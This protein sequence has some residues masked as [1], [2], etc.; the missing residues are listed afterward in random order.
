MREPVKSAPKNMR[1]SV[2][3]RLLNI[4]RERGQTF[5]L[6]LVRYTLERLLYR[7][8][9]SAHRDDFVLKGAML[10]TTWLDNAHRPTRD[11]DLLGFGPSQPEA[12]LA[13]FREI[14]GI[15]AD[16]GVAFDAGALRIERNREDLEY[17]GLRVVTD[18]RIGG[19][20]VRVV[21][22]VGFGDA[23][24]PGL[25]EIELPVLLDLPAPRLRAYPKETVIAEK[26]QAM[27]DLG[28]AN[29]RMKDFY[30]I[31]FLARTFAFEDD[32]LA[33]AIAATFA[34]RKTDIPTEAPDAL[35]DAFAQD[36][37]KRKQWEAFASSI[38]GEPVP[39]DVV[40]KDLRKFLLPHA[41]AARARRAI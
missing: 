18:A 22:D 38:I 3:A 39:L 31:W 25:N 16:D 4:A 33:R 24:E 27:V 8:S 6:L 11:I 14:C 5:D 1:A 23:V 35:S 40:V 2:R 20:K 28:R 29:S 13:V 15:E 41:R 30:D 36:D 34:R 9:L 26:F 7:L 19:A 12:I 10:I 37:A 32:R 17:S 21:V